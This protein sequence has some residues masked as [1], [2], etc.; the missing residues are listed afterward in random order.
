MHGDINVVIWSWCNISPHNIDMYIASME[1]LI[2]QFSNNGTDDRAGVYPV[3]FVFMTAHAN[4]GG[5]GDSSDTR[6]QQIRQHCISHD[7]I[8]FDFSD[9]ENYDPDGNY[10]LDK[11]LT[12]ALYYDSDNDSVRDANW[13]SEYLGRH[14]GSELDQLTHGVDNYDGCGSCAHSDGDNNNSRLNC[15]LKGR[16]VWALF[17]RLAGWS[18]SNAEPKGDINADTFINLEDSVSG[19]QV[20][21]SQENSAQLSAD[22]ND[23]EKINVHESVY[24]LQDIADLRN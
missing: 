17:A 11:L 16:A 21:T 8:L 3:Q 18:G 19:L 10:F 13:A 14:P 9:I 4:G 2:A 12:D 20:M 23:D 6:N 22:V 24:V 7:R 1:W 15:I 5:E